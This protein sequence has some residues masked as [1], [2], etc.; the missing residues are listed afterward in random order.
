MKMIEDIIYTITRE[1]FNRI[2]CSYYIFINATGQHNMSL[3][4][5]IYQNLYNMGY[6]SPIDIY[7]VNNLYSISEIMSLINF[8]D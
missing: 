5:W 8:S 1:E 6:K 4:T 7:K 2:V 3:G